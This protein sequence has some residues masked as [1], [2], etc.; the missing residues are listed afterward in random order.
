MW[1]LSN[2][3][4]VFAPRPLFSVCTEPDEYQWVT[5]GDVRA[6]ALFLASGLQVLL[7]RNSFVGICGR[8]RMEWCVP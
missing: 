1:T 8:N 5:Y 3:L 6:R 4:S 7:P 2:A